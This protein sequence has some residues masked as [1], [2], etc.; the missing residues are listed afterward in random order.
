MTKTRY[1]P[2]TGTSYPLDIDY[3]N[4]LP[5]DVVEVLLVDYEAAMAARAGGSTV[6]LV[7]GHLIITP[8]LPV[9][10]A[11]QAAPFMAEVRATREAILNRLAGIGMAALVS[12]DVEAAD[13]VLV[14]RQALLDITKH[15]AVLAAEAAEDFNSLRAAVKAEYKAIT[16]AAP[17]DMRSAFNMVDA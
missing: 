14:A 11:Q 9:P 16:A 8:P 12:G 10:F 15:P 6:A 7:D 13:A 1:S 4:G 5:A 3:P 2:S 17:A